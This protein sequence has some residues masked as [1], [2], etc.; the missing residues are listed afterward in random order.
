MALPQSAIIPEAGSFALYVL[1]KV[2]GDAANVINQCQQL[3]AI[4]NQVNSDF[5]ANGIGVSAAFSKSFCDKQGIAVP[6]SFTSFKPLGKG[7]ITAPS[8][9]CDILVHLHADRHDLNFYVMRQF[10]LPVSEDVEVIDE[11]MGFRYLDARDMTGFIDGTE[12]P[13]LEQRKDVA[14]IAEGKHA[15]GSFVMVQRF[16]HKLPAWERL[17]QTA[18]EKIIGRTKPDSIELDDVPPASHVGR[19]DIKEE[20]K[21]LKIV[22]HSLPYGSVTKEHGLLFIAY[23]HTQHNFDQMLSSMYG[24]TDGKTDMMLKFTDAVTGAYFFAP[25]Q[26]ALAAL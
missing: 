24:E 9:D 7:N 8:T 4:A 21:G 26:E 19:V 23:C 18:Q 13:K 15:G 1:L 11:T 16:V 6:D 12:N 14:L 22:R 20:G 10:L 17:S 25:S 2:R 3:H 5:S